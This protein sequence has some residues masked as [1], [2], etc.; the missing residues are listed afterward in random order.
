MK[1]S[2]IDT[3]T[4]HRQRKAIMMIPFRLPH[5]R[6]ERH[7]LLVSMLSCVVISSRSRLFFS[8]IVCMCRH[9][10]FFDFIYFLCVFC[11]YLS[12][13]LPVCVCRNSESSRE[14]RNLPVD[15]IERIDARAYSA[16]VR[17]IIHRSILHER[18][19]VCCLLLLLY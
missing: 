1:T 12:L 18:R 19:C 9:N 16:H 14:K 5:V 11:S 3:H 13:F 17:D 4:R 6:V 10:Y 8:S 7:F 15:I 2:K